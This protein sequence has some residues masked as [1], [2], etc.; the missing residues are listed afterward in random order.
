MTAAEDSKDW[1]LN[2]TEV[3]PASNTY[4]QILAI[5]ARIFHTENTEDTE[6]TTV[7]SVSSVFSVVS[8][9]RKDRSHRL[10]QDWRETSAGS[11]IIP[12]A[13]AVSLPPSFRS[14][15]GRSSVKRKSVVITAIAIAVLLIPVIALR[16][17]FNANQFK[18]MLESKLVEVLGRKV[19]VGN[20][21][22]AILSGGISIDHVSISDDPAF[23]RSP[24][25]KA[26]GMTAGV[27]LRPLI[28]SNKL[29]V[30]SFSILEPE[31]I[32]LHSRAGTWN[33]SSLGG[34]SAKTKSK[35]M[36]YESPTDLSVQKLI[37]SGGKIHV[38][39]VGSRETPSVYTD[40]N[41]EASDLSYTSQFPFKVTAKGPGHAALM[42]EGKA[43]LINRNDFSHTPLEAKFEVQHLDLA[44]S[45][46]INLSS[47]IAGLVDLRGTLASDGRQLRSN[48]V[49]KATKLKLVAAG[50][51]SAVPVKIDYSADYDL[52]RETG[53]IKQGDVHIGNA[54]ARLSGTY[55]TK[56][57]STIVN[58][59]LNGQGMPV[60]DLEGAL[61]AL[62]IT[63]PAGASLRSGTMALNLAL[64][65]P[66]DRLLV[67]G[68]VNLSNARLAG[69]SL[70]SK[71][72]VLSA[73]TGLGSAGS[74]TDI[75][76]LSAHLQ[77]DP[78]G[79]RMEDL[80]LIVPAIG[81]I[82]GAGNISPRGQLD[83]KMV[84]K[85]A[86]AGTGST[87]NMITST[88]SQFG[89]GDGIPFL[90]QGTTSNPQF[91]PDV[92]GVVGNV[93]RSRIGGLN[94]RTDSSGQ[95]DDV[96]SGILGGLLGK[97]KKP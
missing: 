56:G 28:F 21:S 60:S 4:P 29:E 2:S 40:V 46:F 52:K 5:P 85:L 93:L 48:G 33:F 1:T 18:P 89:G 54:L 24:F 26:K 90:I 14:S 37:I 64:S 82:R 45:G 66:I 57:E 3:V 13:R 11:M 71:L 88:L 72:A 97:K 41:L 50:S 9:F 91:V 25:L 65:G 10:M 62:G 83:Y 12:S 81:M 27:A 22:L 73:F 53:V 78:A 15:P 92:A 55:G 69:F 17:L 36:Q 96:I 84:A 79:T 58:M 42:L 35:D 32:L 20:L 68:P 49:A 51:P 95:S 43:G 31:V 19:E 87:L 80:S 70:G 61:P 6:K 76:T 44:T 30:H 59:K 67:T 8:L 23:S 39:T 63:L 74:D 77:F 7:F 86:N 75:R 47:G 38:G 94:N 34:T 16:L